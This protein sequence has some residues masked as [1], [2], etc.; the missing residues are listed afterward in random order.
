MTFKLVIFDCDG[1]LVDSETLTAETYVKVAKELGAVFELADAITRFKGAKMADCVVAIEERLGHKV[2]ENFVSDFR[3]RLAETFK[4]E[5]KPIE[6]IGE[7]INK[8]H[9]PICVASSGPMEKIRLTLGLTGLLPKFEGRIF[10]SYDIQKWKPDPDIFLHAA[11]SLNVAPENCAVIEDSLLGVRAGLAAG[12]Q[13]FSY[14]D[15]TEAKLFKETGAT[16]FHRMQDLTRI[17]RL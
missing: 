9:L 1:V 13:V 10:S 5:L 7:V 3:L 14:C 4:T 16:P 8:I 2:P 12:M 17:L 6:G 11:R 15:V